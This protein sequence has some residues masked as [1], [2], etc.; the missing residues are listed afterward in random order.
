[1]TQS[2]AYVKDMEE[3]AKSKGKSWTRRPSAIL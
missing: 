3:I 2:G 1:M